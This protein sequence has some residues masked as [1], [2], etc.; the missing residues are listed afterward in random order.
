MT[1]GMNIAS[2][3]LDQKDLNPVF[4]NRDSSGARVVT[5]TGSRE[6]I[7]TIDPCLTVNQEGI[8]LG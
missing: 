1:Q 7:F 4:V 8:L 2:L 6:K 3:R 5:R